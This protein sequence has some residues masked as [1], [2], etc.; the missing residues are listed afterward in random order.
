ML[1]SARCGDEVARRCPSCGSGVGEGDRFCATCGRRLAQ[2]GGRDSLP[3]IVT[4]G[5]RKWVTVLFADL[6]G[7]TGLIDGLDAEEADAFLRSTVEAMREAV[8]R[9]GGVV[10]GLQGDGIMALFGAPVAHEDHAARASFAALEIPKLVEEA[11]GGRGRVRVGLHSGE[12]MVR[13]V[14][15]DLSADYIATGST[16][17]LAARME[18]A[19]T[20]GV[21]LATA[22][23]VRLA[24]G[25]VVV[26][27][28]ERLEAKGFV[29]PIDVY[30]IVGRTGARGSWE[31]RR[32]RDLSRFVGRDTELE[33]LFGAVEL[34]TTTGIGRMIGIEG[35]P[36]VG[37]SRLLHEFLAR[38]PPGMGVIRSQTDPYNTH[39]AY[40]PIRQ[41]LAR[42][43][44][45][46]T[47]EGESPVEAIRSRLAPLGRRLEDLAPTLAFIVDPALAPELADLDGAHRRRIVRDAIRDVLERASRRTPLILVIEDLQWIDSDSLAAIDDLL[48][49][50]G[51]HPLLV[52]VTFRPEFDHDW[53]E[54]PTFD[55][56]RLEPLE[57]DAGRVLIESLLGSHPSVAGLR[58]VL[59]DRSDGIPLFVEE[60][61]RELV[62]SGAL[63]GERGGYRLE[64]DAA[65][66][67]IPDTIRAV[68]AS[69]IDRLP[70]ESKELL[71]VASVIGETVTGDLLAS[72]AGSGGASMEG[73]LDVLLRSE[74]LD[75]HSP[76]VS[77]E[78]GHNLTREVAYE[79]IPAP[80]RRQLH[81]RTVD[82]LL[83]MGPPEENLERIAM[84]AQRAERWEETARFSLAAAERAEK[85]SSYVDAARFLSAALTALRR[86]PRTPDHLAQM[87]DAHIAMR[88]AR[89]GAGVRMSS[90][91]EDLAEA[92]TLAA[93]LDDL[94]R[95]TR[96][97]LHSSYVA[98]TIG[99]HPV[100]LASALKAQSLAERLGTPQ[101]R[102]EA[103]LAEAQARVVAGR[104]KGVI[105]LLA[106]E[107]G[108]FRDHMRSQ[109]GMVGMR[110]TWALM[111]LAEANTLT[112][113]FD[114]ANRLSQEA[115]TLARGFDRPFDLAYACWA[116]GSALLL[117]SRVD[118]A[119]AVLREGLAIAQRY[120]LRW[121]SAWLGAF[122]GFALTLAGQMDDAADV[123]AVAHRDTVG[124]EAPGID[125]RLDVHRARLA[126]EAGDRSLGAEL[127]DRALSIAVQTGDATVEIDARRCAAIAAED[128][129]VA[130]D[131]LRRA[132]DIARREGLAPFLAW[133]LVELAGVV[134]PRTPEGRAALGEAHDMMRQMGLRRRRVRR[135]V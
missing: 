84:H 60:A 118:E 79:E 122:L 126:V 31:A 6:V 133:S 95:M 121:A 58:R 129:D 105:E 112:G 73:A 15:G 69:R 111:H 54:R 3:T 12:V 116:R 49:S 36:G 117:V 97:S 115:L 8:N 2:T 103:I 4:A 66:I 96:V 71:Q 120:E 75:E 91:L 59:L 101:M 98:S 67:D 44:P 106:P 123:L 113:R 1:F 68:I 82:A 16:V 45:E 55:E 102:A 88:V 83:E 20:P 5:E 78:F 63:T 62:E 41:L 89:T 94:A 134:G 87:V 7:S 135:K 42:W 114:E 104:P 109:H 35:E 51:R 53:S 34:A 37:K 18:Q 11:T 26:E 125:T 110:I 64:G 124:M 43:V 108:Y 21:P 81:G 131:H 57:A 46:T 23:T 93:E 99:D 90:V 107:L 52:L 32:T 13:S 70:F 17:H 72:V 9:Y 40:L 24:E 30:D 127:A 86:L 76:G 74:L 119:V 61:V 100:A 38:R 92:E 65:G 128:A 29:I 14:G 10:N 28:R 80:R 27:S 33:R 77:Y 19:A 22:A 132:V 85:R 130:A 39:A 47:A 56:I 48:E 50:V 25:Y